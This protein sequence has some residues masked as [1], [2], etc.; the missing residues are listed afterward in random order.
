MLISVSLK[1]LFL[2]Y[3]RWS[4]RRSVAIKALLPPEPLLVSFSAFRMALFALL[5]NPPTIPIHV[6]V[7]YIDI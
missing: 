6:V 5:F 4:K 2:F 3:R 7:L 1:I